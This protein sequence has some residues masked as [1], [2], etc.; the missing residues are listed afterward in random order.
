MILLMCLED[1]LSSQFE[2]DCIEV[3]DETKETTYGLREWLVVI[4][5]RDDRDRKKTDQEQVLEK[6]GRGRDKE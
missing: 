5:R 2:I 6:K 4:Q 3:K 1:Y